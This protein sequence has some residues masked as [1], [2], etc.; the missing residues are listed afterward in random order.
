[1]GKQYCNIRK[2]TA[3]IQ[4]IVNNEPKEPEDVVLADGVNNFN[5]YIVHGD[6][7][8]VGAYINGAQR[9]NDSNLAKNGFFIID[10][11]DIDLLS[12]YEYSIDIGGERAGVNLG[13]NV[14]IRAKHKKTF[15]KIFQK[16]YP[17]DDGYNHYI[18]KNNNPL[19][20]RGCNLIQSKIKKRHS[21]N[22]SGITGVSKIFQG[23]YEY[24]YACFIKGKIVKRKKFSVLKYKNAEQ[25]A[26]GMRKKW[27]KRYL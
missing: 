15:S 22:T 20:L 9:A 18:Y 25:L 19:D 23:N 13:I 14:K 7:V 11:N 26:I 8:C 27:E 10:K 21:N 4:Q 24:W 12:K 5:D 3:E 16:K 17:L 2:Y 6:I 1:M